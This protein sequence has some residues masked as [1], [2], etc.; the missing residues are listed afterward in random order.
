M[1]ITSDFYRATKDLSPHNRAIFSEP[2]ANL[3]NT[4]AAFFYKHLTIKDTEVI[5]FE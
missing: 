2:Y 3:M 4:V 1:E 5:S